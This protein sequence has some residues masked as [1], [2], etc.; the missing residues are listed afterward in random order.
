MNRFMVEL[1]V[2]WEERMEEAV[3]RK[4]TIYQRVWCFP[5]EV[6]CRDFAGKSPYI[7]IED[8]ESDWRCGEGEE[9]PDQLIGEV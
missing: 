3:E 4:K 6:G 8:H 9:T 5:V 1:T 2:P 7:Y